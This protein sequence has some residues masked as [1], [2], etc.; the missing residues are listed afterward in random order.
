MDNVLLP[1]GHDLAGQLMIGQQSTAHIDQIG[2]TGSDDF[3]HLRGIIQPAQRGH[4]HRH[5]FF[6]FRS[7]IY[8]DA[9]GQKHRR[10][11]T[12]VLPAAQRKKVLIAGGGPGGL[13]AAQTAAQRGIV[14]LQTRNG[15]LYRQRTDSD[16]QSVRLQGFYQFRC[17]LCIQRQAGGTG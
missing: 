2:L 10:I 16:N 4:R 12:E 13:K 11:G 6:D 17:D 9:M 14:I 8:I 1:I 3:F 5:V 15:R 7:Q